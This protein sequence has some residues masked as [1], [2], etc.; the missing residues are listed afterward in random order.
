MSFRAKSRN[1][2]SRS[3]PSTSTCRRGNARMRHEI[4]SHSPPTPSR[5]TSRA[6]HS[7]MRISGLS[8]SSD[9]GSWSLM[10]EPSS[11]SGRRLA[12]QGCRGQARVTGALPQTP[13]LRPAISTSC[14]HGTSL[15]PAGALAHTKKGQ[16]FG[17]SIFRGPSWA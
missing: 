10:H 1:S 9:L 14:P 15:A 4:P 5:V 3:T 8:H 2:H 12:P 13:P 16:P 6:S 11:V 7:R 17:L